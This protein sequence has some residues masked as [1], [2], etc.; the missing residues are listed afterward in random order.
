MEE[1]HI[2]K[3]Y[4]IIRR[5]IIQG[6]VD[7]IRTQKAGYLLLKMSRGLGKSFTI[8]GIIR[9]LLER[10]DNWFAV[11][12]V[13]SKD[14]AERNFVRQGYMLKNKFVAER[15]WKSKGTTFT[16]SNGSVL[17]FLSLNDATK[18]E[19]NR[20]IHPNIIFQDEAQGIVDYESYMNVFGRM[21]KQ[22]N[23][24]FIVS[25][26]GSKEETSLA[27]H[28]EAQH[29]LGKQN[30]FLVEKTLL[31][32]YEEDPCEYYSQQIEEE[33]ARYTVTSVGYE[34]GMERIRTLMT[35]EKHPGFKREILCQHIQGSVIGGL[36]FPE[37][38]ERNI[39]QED[40]IIDPEKPVYIVS[41]FG[42]NDPYGSIFVQT[43]GEDLIVFAE[44]FNRSKEKTVSMFANDLAQ[45]MAQ[46]GLASIQDLQGEGFEKAIEEELKENVKTSEEK[47]PYIPERED[48][49]YNPYSVKR[50]NVQ[51]KHKHLNFFGDEHGRGANWLRFLSLYFNDTTFQPVNTSAS[52]GVDL[53]KQLIQSKQIKIH[54]SCRSLIEHISSVTIEERKEMIEKY[55][56]LPIDHKKSHLIVTLSYIIQILI[57]NE[58]IPLVRNPNR[59]V[60]ENY[61]PVKKEEK[62][63]FPLPF[64][65]DFFTPSSKAS[66]FNKI[67]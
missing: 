15:G 37:F 7:L 65:M 29:K 12:M 8:I 64:S 28:L 40:Y 39:I 19:Q 2:E 44:M 59:K 24:L 46:V 51:F 21:G 23:S 63:N 55:N 13:K 34:D 47:N 45:A 32:C 50:F 36:A 11:V 14:S 58:T 54:H 5:P 16:F 66:K 17:D 48:E 1:E 25:Y 43:Q 18:V 10:N 49:K 26:T 35:Y 30:S 67:I 3:H 6:V 38:G 33:K 61:T 56:N 22:K 20:G 57:G 53:I 52:E 9:E 31:D 42:R 60:V 27:Q 62:M 41:D 4:E